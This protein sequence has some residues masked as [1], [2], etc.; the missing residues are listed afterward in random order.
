MGSLQEWCEPGTQKED[1]RAPVAV[2]ALLSLQLLLKQHSH[3][4][5]PGY[6]D[7]LAQ[8]LGNGMLFPKADVQN[9]LEDS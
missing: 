5:F 3:P 2:W 7:H 9:V 1:T 4:H 8:D 6:V